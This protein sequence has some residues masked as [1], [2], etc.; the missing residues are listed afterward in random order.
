MIRFRKGFEVPREREYDKG[1]YRAIGE[2]LAC[3]VFIVSIDEIPGFLK[4]WTPF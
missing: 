4:A 1:S 3:A 2:D